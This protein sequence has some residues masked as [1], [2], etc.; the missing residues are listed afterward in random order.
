MSVQE[1]DQ[2]L[3]ETIQKLKTEPDVIKALT[4][5]KEQL[6]EM[7]KLQKELALIEA[8][9]FHEKKKSRALCRT[10]KRSWIRGCLTR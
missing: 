7:I 5:V 2:D 6:P 10:L 1:F 4:Y 8:P 3:V 9:S